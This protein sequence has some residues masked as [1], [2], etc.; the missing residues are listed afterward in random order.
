MMIIIKIIITAYC[1]P[2]KVSDKTFNKLNDAHLTSKFTVVDA[3]KT[4]ND[5][6][7]RPR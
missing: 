3:A 4:V 1:T 7:Q 2:E 5:N 6:R